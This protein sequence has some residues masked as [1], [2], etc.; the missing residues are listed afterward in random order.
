MRGGGSGCFSIK[1]IFSGDV[2][3]TLVVIS[4][5]VSVGGLFFMGGQKFK[6]LI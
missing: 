5:V 1:L 4:I 2:L 3:P 6:G